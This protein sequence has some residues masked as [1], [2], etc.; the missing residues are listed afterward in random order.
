MTVL[1][2]AS[3]RITL[4]GALCSF[5]SDAIGASLPLATSKM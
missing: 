4:T 5:S 2:A 1:A 3:N